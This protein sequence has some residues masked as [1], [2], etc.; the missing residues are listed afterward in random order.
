MVKLAELVVTEVDPCSVDVVLLADTMP[1]ELK[2]LEEPEKLDDDFK[3][4]TEPEE[5]EDA[6]LVTNPL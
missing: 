5:P 4:A 3:E 6:E 1:E 2:E